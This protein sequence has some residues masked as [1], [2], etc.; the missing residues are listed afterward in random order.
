MVRAE[1]MEQVPHLAMYVQENTHLIDAPISSYIL[2]TVV[3]YLIDPNNQVRYVLTSRELSS[4][5]SERI[6]NATR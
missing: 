2:P 3:K 4:M 6:H 1:L 5:F